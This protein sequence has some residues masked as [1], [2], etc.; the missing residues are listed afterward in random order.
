MCSTRILF[1]HPNTPDYA[2]DGLFHGLRLLL[3]KNCIDYPRIDYM[4]SD[5]PKEKWEGVAN[6]GK[7][8]YGHLKDSEELAMYRFQAFH[9]IESYSHIIVSNPSTFGSGLKQVL[10]KVNIRK[11]HSKVVWVDGSDT[12]RLFPFASLKNLMFN[13]P[14]QLLLTFKISYYFKR[15][16]AGFKKAAP[17]LFRWLCLQYKIFPFSISIP[18]CYLIKP[19]KVHKTKFF[20]DYL[21]D[22]ELAEMERSKYGKLGKHDFLFNSE[23]TY[24]Q[25]IDQSRFGPT[26]KRAGWDALRHYEYAARGAIL[27]FKNL[28]AKPIDCAPHGLNSTNSITYQNYHQLME[29]IESLTTEQYQFLQQN[30]YSWIKQHTTIAEATRF[31][32]ILQNN[33]S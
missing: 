24:F 18:E 33:K 21:V 29:I 16:F 8:L 20:P 28:D 27:C 5:Y 23:N 26:T 13:Y 6:Q 15:E 3:G 19:E 14:Q 12:N 17:P 25:D 7:V 30:T 2:G 10:K 4:Y 11:H 31:L 22:E 9:E 1:L 32:A